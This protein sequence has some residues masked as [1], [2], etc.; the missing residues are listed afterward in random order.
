M[1]VYGWSDLLLGTGTLTLR[2]TFVHHIQNLILGCLASF[3]LSCFAHLLCIII[4]IFLLQSISVTLQS[5]LIFLDKLALSPIVQGHL[6]SFGCQVSLVLA[7]L[8]GAD[9]YL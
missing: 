6:G 7:Q 9:K 1:A 5:F 2:H 3:P 8:L 4:F